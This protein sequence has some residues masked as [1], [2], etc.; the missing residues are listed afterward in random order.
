MK[1][2][3]R[4]DRGSLSRPQR[5]D[6]ALFVEGHAARVHGPSDPLRYKHG[7]EYR[8]VA[9]LRRIAAQL[10][11]KPVTLPHPPGLIMHGAVPRV[12]GRVDEAWL[13]GDHVAVRLRIDA[14]EA[15]SAIES[16]TKELSL[17]YATDVD[18]AKFQRE[19]DVDHLAIISMARCGRT[20]SLR[21]DDV[22]LDCAETC[23]CSTEIDQSEHARE[24]VRMA[25]KTDKQRAD[26]LETTVATLTDEVK[27]LEGLI[28][29]G[30]TAA[31]TEAIRKEKQRADA[32][33]EKVRELDAAYQAGVR[34]RS[35]LLLEASTQLGATFRM[36]DLTERQIHEAV[37]KRLDASVN[38]SGENDDQ[39]RGRY[40][41]LLALAAR[42]V[43]SQQRVAEILGRENRTDAH[44]AEREESYED[45]E[46]N[47]WKTTLKNGRAA[48]EG[49]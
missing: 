43:E 48:A 21:V 31:E 15:A 28:A 45:H 8:D 20:C 2:V 5:R 32:A 16:G 40:Q 41:T 13:D 12:V 18:A 46:K 35:K 34:A 44:R 9:E 17:G 38:T 24:S 30:A 14:A 10:P 29:A 25:D 47:R 27:R 49:R 42:N 11:G 7:D 36:D 22:R 4:V 26:E 33:E 37:I 23:A 19:T 6:G 39:V 1:Q 3:V